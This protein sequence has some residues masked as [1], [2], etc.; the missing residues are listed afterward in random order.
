MFDAGSLPEPLARAATLSWQRFVDGLG[1]DLQTRT[2]FWLDARPDGAIELARTFALSEFAAAVATAQPEVFVDFLESNAFEA[3]PVADFVGE[4]LREVADVE[5]LK[6]ALRR[7]RNAAMLH[8]IWRDL[9]GRSDVAETTK[10]LTRLADQLINAAVLRLHDWAVANDS[11][12]VGAQ[13]GRAQQLVVI[14]LGKLGARELNLSSDVDLIFAYPEAGET[15]SGSRT[16]QQFFLRLSQKLIQ[17]ID[18]ITVDGFVFRVDM[19]LRPYGDSGALVLSFDAI[20]RYY[21][22]QGRDWERYAWIRA[23]PCAGDIESGHRLIEDLKPFVFRRYLDFGA[24]QALREMKGR[25]DAERNR[26]AMRNDVKLGPGGIREVEF[27][28]QMHQLIWAG[29]QPA[30][31]CTGVVETLDALARQK[32]LSLEQARQLGGAYR[33]LRNVEHRLQAIRDEQTQLLPTGALDR[34]RVATGMGFADYEALVAALDSHRGVVSRAFQ[35]LIQADADDGMQRWREPWLANDVPALAA[36]LASSGFGEVD[37]LTGLMRRLCTAR[38]RPWVGA[39]GR[40]RLDAL[41]PLLLAEAEKTLRPGLTLARF[42]PLLEATVRRSAYYV[43]LLENASALRLLVEICGASRW[44]ADELSRHPVLL[45]ELLDP[46]LLYTIPDIDA[47][48]ADLRARLAFAEQGGEEAELEALRSFKETHQFRVAACEVRGILPLMNVSDYLTFLAEVIL[49]EALQ[50]AWRRTAEAMTAPPQAFAIIGFGKLGG[51]ELGP[52]S[53]LDI[54]FLHDLDPQHNPFLHR[55]VR[56]LLHILTARTHSGALYDVDTRLRPSGQ[57]GTMVSSLAAFEHYQNHDAWVWEHQA[58]VRARPVAGDARV[59]AAFERIRRDVL[60]RPRD[61]AQLR[62][63]IVDM[64]R[65]IGESADAPVDLKRGAGGIVDIEFM[66]QYLALAWAAEHPSLAD[67]TDNVRILDTAAKVGLLDG[68]TAAALKD[69][70]LALRS[71]R[72][73]EALDIPDDGRAREVLDRNAALIREQWSVL[74]TPDI[75]KE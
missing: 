12:P 62:Q 52:G 65:R 72:H 15:R 43:L 49:Q 64:R 17:V 75:A 42:V 45:D 63:A 1:P 31:Q 21:E 6:S 25:I 46:A 57:A 19:R 37:E 69:A 20:E 71:E 48:R 56:R 73:R 38:D 27:T 13:S 36:A 53:D 47:L 7:L 32:L 70:Y 51:L 4:S 68:Q 24:I 5:A 44:L 59:C 33:F 54:V 50:I 55:M 41:I 11:A 26:S 35:S 22:E 14:A 10:S 9:N 58:L 16:N 74:L 66:V 60:C 67:W 34:A 39:E 40:A 2:N 30:L 8:I 3:A 61:R 28:A 18:S 29:R 23:R